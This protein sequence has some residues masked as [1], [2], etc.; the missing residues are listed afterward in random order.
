[1]DLNLVD[2]LRLSHPI[3]AIVVVYPI[4]GLVLSRSVLTRQRRLATSNK[5]KN[6]DRK[7]IPANV[8]IEHQTSGQWLAIAVIGSYLIACGRPTLNFWFKMNLLNQQPF[9]VMLITL[10]YGVA[11]GSTWAIFRAIPQR[12]WR[13]GFAVMNAMA[14]VL[15][16]FQDG[17]YRNDA[18]WF[19]S[20]F[21]F[22][23]A[24]ALLM[25]F[26]LAIF[27]E[28]NRDRSNR[29]RQIHVVANVVATVLFMV[30]G[31]TG[32]RDLLEIPLSWQEKTIYACDTDKTSPTYKTCPKLK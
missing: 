32:A 6:D 25:V 29:W 17:V 1:M 12:S 9:K 15:V 20:H 21:Y 2:W 3:L 26:S 4:L 30:Q 24:T 19:Q 7:K 31:I 14:L 11:V 18:V 13:I 5:G 22:G 28:I 27:P 16:G 23:L 10:I 8:G